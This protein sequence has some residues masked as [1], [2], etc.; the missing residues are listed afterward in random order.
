MIDRNFQGFGKELFTDAGRYALLFGEGIDRS[1]G[2][3]E[4]GE[5]QGRIAASS[6]ASDSKALERRPESDPAHELHVARP[7]TL[8]MHGVSLRAQRRLHHAAEATVVDGNP[9]RGG[10]CG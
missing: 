4:A 1:A 7:L 10:L 3:I 2:A 6:A 8:R 5:Q 9:T